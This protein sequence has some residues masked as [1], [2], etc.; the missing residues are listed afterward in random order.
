MKKSLFFLFLCLFS[1]SNEHS[2]NESPRPIKKSEPKNEVDLSHHFPKEP[3]VQQG[4]SCAV[5]SQVGLFEAACHRHLGHKI[6]LSEAYLFYRSVRG[7]ILIG[8]KYEKTPRFFSQYDI[9]KD[10]HMTSERIKKGYVCDSKDLTFD[11][12]FIEAIKSEDLSKIEGCVGQKLKEK[13]KV[14]KEGVF[15]SSFSDE[16]KKC[17]DKVPAHKTEKYSKEKALELLNKGIPFACTGN[18]VYAHGAGQHMFLIT[19]YSV[20][21]GEI[22][23]K[24]RD[25]IEKTMLKFDCDL[26]TY[27]P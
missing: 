26:I 8:E 5:Y 1:F 21:Q 19:G 6:K 7:S 20:E 2:Q 13:A 25:S 14:T 24:V 22:K 23:W 27:Y 3:P 9:C 12:D 18:A 17:I 10:Y 11:S 16:I 15:V 4:G